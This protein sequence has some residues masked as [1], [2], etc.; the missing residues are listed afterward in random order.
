M[1]IQAMVRQWGNSLGIILPKEIVKNEEL[2][3]KEEVIVEIT[4]KPDLRKIFSS[5]KPKRPVQDIK[6]EIKAGWQPEH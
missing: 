2:K 4:K 1:K 3:P 5:L 6:D